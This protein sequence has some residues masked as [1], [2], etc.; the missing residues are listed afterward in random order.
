M[1]DYL[2]A[3]K[4]G[5]IAD[6]VIIAFIL[7]LALIGSARG[8]SAMIIKFLGGILSL[9]LAFVLCK[10]CAAFLNTHFGVTDKIA[11]GLEGGLKKLFGE[12]LCNMPLSEFESS[13]GGSLPKFIVKLLLG[14]A[15]GGLPPET[16][17][18]QALAPAFAYYVALVIGFIACYILLRILFFILGRFLK[19]LL[20]FGILGAADRILGL[21]LG[22]AQGILI[23]YIALSV[24]DILPFSFL[25]GLKNALADSALARLMESINIFGIFNPVEYIKG[26]IGK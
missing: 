25:G 7:L 2:L 6:I 12:Q 1:V 5:T 15:D 4:G 24:I 26:A 23:C 17:V 22:A 16:T 19:S 9:I 20:R 11:A 14:L 18:G 3:V 10:N 21:I 8:F 13:S